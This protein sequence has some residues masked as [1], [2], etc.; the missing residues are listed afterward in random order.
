MASFVLIFLISF[1]TVA[2]LAFATLALCNLS[3][4][5]VLITTAIITLIVIFVGEAL[6]LGSFRSP[7]DGILRVIPILFW[8]STLC[9]VIG[10]I[11]AA[12]LVL[13]IRGWK[14]RRNTDSR[15]VV[16]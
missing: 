1:G 12:C 13:A 15:S 5:G 4:R 2:L 11:I 6:L 14:A 10:A 7:G 9:V 3:K 8:L 16:S